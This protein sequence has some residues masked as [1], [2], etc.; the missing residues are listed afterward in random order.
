[1][2]AAIL[3][4]LSDLF[5]REALARRKRKQITEAERLEEISFELHA[6]FEQADRVEMLRAL[7]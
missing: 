5:S 4:E 1:M 2:R 3:A 7:R 6:K